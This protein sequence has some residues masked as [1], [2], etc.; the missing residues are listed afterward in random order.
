MLEFLLALSVAVVVCCW[1]DY[2]GC[3]WGF[4]VL[5]IGVALNAVDGIAAG[6]APWGAADTA[7]RLSCGCF[8]W[9][10]IYGAAAGGASDV[11][12]GP[13][14]VAAGAGVLQTGEALQRFKVLLATCQRSARVAEL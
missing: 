7:A 13:V 11:V 6:G 10:A 4:V 12:A 1:R 9:V 2:W 3:C 14:A 5:P 8:C